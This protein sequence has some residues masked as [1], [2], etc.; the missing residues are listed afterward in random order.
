MRAGLVFG[1]LCLSTLAVSAGCS[2]TDSTD[3][4]GSGTPTGSGGGGTTGSGGAGGAGGTGGAGG[5]GEASDLTGTLVD[6]YLHDGQE[7]SRPRTDITLSALVPGEGDAFT[8]IPGTIADD[9]TF[10]IPAVPAGEVYLTL[11]YDTGRSSFIATSARSI[12]LGRLFGGRPDAAPVTISPTP[13]ILN[14]TGLS[15][16]QD[17][18]SMEL[19][20]PGSGAWG[21]LGFYENGP[22]PGDVSLTGATFDAVELIIPFLIE[23]NKGDTALLTQLVSSTTGNT[24]TLALRKALQ[25]ASFT[26]VDGQPTTITGTFEDVPQE[27]HSVDWKL[28]QFIA[29]MDDVHPQALLVSHDVS[30]YAE[31]GGPTRSTN[32]IASLLAE[33]YTTDSADVTLD[34]AH[35]NPLPD[36]WGSYIGASTSV[37]VAVT[38][39]G[40]P[41]PKSLLGV[42]SSW[43]V[44]GAWTSAEMA[45]VVSPPKDVRVNGTATT[46]PLTGVGVTPTVSWSA[47]DLGAPSMYRVTVRQ[48]QPNAATLTLSTVYTAGTQI[49]IPPGVLQAG[50]YYYLRVAAVTN[51]DLAKPFLAAPEGGNADAITSYLSP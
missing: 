43:T 27:P 35:G 12:D 16:W 32:S 4:D 22:A 50:S 2:C 18:D 45:P 7:L 51:Q 17:S 38:P 3:T 29:L 40:F 23:G 19:Y 15:P 21:I 37:R 31:P 25:P 44:K 39:P 42:V 14:V 41:Q 6:V 49:R 46:E 33:A 5:A 34:L 9:G 28:S 11:T 30:V 8:S 26:Q 1:L 24:T 20:S 48:L 36:S 47:P 13:L 10:T